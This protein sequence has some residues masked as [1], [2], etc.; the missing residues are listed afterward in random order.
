[1]GENMNKTQ[2]K[3]IGKIEIDLDKIIEENP[4]LNVFVNVVK[5]DFNEEYCHLLKYLNNHRDI[6]IFINYYQDRVKDLYELGT[7]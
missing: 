3:Q 6:G 4:E 5:Q 1:M 7:I 2:Q